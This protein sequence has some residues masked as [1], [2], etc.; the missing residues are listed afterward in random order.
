MLTVDAVADFSKLEDFARRQARTFAGV[1]QMTMLAHPE[2][3]AKTANPM[4]GDARAQLTAQKYA[5]RRAYLPR[6]AIGKVLK[7]ELR[8]RYAPA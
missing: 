8:A 2:L 7:Q 6:S 3:N 4:A 5:T 1:A